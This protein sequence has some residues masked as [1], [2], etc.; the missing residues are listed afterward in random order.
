[1]KK[2]ES[3]LNVVRLKLGLK[4]SYRHTYIYNHKKPSASTQ[5]AASLMQWDDGL[6]P[7]RGVRCQ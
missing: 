3:N 6:T 7:S 1:M 2:N 4:V 5:S